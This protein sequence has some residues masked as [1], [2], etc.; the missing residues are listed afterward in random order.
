[1]ENYLYTARTIQGAIFSGDI[2]AHNRLAAINALKQRGYFLLT[3]QKTSLSH[4]I[5]NLRNARKA[6]TKADLSVFARQ[7]ATML[8]A[9]VKLDQAILTLSRQYA[10]NTLGKVLTQ[11]HENIAESSSFSQAIAK[12]PKIFD[13]VFL[14][15][16]T[17]SEQTGQL[18]QGLDTLATQ[19]KRQS[20]TTK[21]I[22]S[23]MTYPIFLLILSFAVVTLLMSF[24][25]PRFISLFTQADEQLPL[26]T[27]I[28]VNITEALKTSWM[29]ILIAVTLAAITVF[30]LTKNQTFKLWLDSKILN[31]PII[32]NL[33]LTAQQAA[34][35]QSMGSLLTGAVRIAQALDCAA[36]TVKNSALQKEILSVKQQIIKGKSL[37]ESLRE[38]GLFSEMVANMAEVGEQTGQLARMMLEI[39]DIYEKKSHSDIESATTL[40][41]PAMIVFIGII[42]GFVVMAILLPIFQ[43]SSLT[44]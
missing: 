19:L 3:V 16:I 27:Q 44:G 6:V 42:I 32:G 9:S 36:A 5:L 33:I 15:V 37:A 13:Q 10:G 43:T 11:I 40:L 38:K 7:L 1:M 41:A 17:A 2:Q 22:W 29:F 34:F 26:C 18:A 23:A 8:K 24:V 31:C 20:E 4:Q 14:G 28:L 35:A 25:V 39:G 30:K 12:H 21:K